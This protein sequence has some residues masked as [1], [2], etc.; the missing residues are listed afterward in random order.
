MRRFYESFLLDDIDY[1]S[2]FDFDPRNVSTGLRE[3]NVKPNECEMANRIYIL[4]VLVIPSLIQN[5]RGMLKRQ[6]RSV[7]YQHWPGAKQIQY[8][9]QRGRVPLCYEFIITNFIIF[10]NVRKN[11][12]LAQTF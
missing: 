5:R 7:G 10:L 9:N 6:K 2:K 8:V 4:P 12:L 3:L 1:V 11:P